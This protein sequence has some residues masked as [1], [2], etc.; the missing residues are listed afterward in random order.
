MKATRCKRAQAPWQWLVALAFAVLPLVS[1]AQTAFTT[2][3]VNVRAGPDRSFP[4]VAWLQPG[5]RVSVVGCI[6][7][8][9]WCD[10]VVGFNRGWVYSRYLSMTHRNQPTVILHNGAWLGIPLIT[11]GLVPYWDLHYRNRPWW[12]DR[13]AWAS[14]PPPPVW[15]PPPH[16]PP[17]VVRPPPPRPPPGAR[18]PAPRPPPSGRPPSGPRPEPPPFGPPP[19]GEV[20]GGRPPSGGRPPGR[21]GSNTGSPGG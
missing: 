16:R 17:P 2:Q 5:T 14:R 7:G 11:F 13:N 18:P 8:W 1:A 15:H 21:P 10:V 6:D 9:R 20:P 19:A 3:A 4:L 12:N